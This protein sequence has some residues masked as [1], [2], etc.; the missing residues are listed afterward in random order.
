MNI[1]QWVRSPTVYKMALI[2]VS[3]V[4]AYGW[5]L[6]VTLEKRN[7]LVQSFSQEGGYLSLADY[8]WSNRSARIAKRKLGLDGD[9]CHFYGEDD[10]ADLNAIQEAAKSRVGEDVVDPDFTIRWEGDLWMR[11]KKV[12]WRVGYFPSRP[13][14]CDDPLP[15]ACDTGWCL[16]ILPAND[17]GIEMAKRM[18]AAT[19][20]RFEVRE[21]STRPTMNPD[22]ESLLSRLDLVGFGILGQSKIYLDRMLDY[23]STR[24]AGSKANTPHSSDGSSSSCPL[25]VF[26]PSFAEH[27]ASRQVPMSITLA[28]KGV[29]GMILLENPLRGRRSHSVDGERLHSMGQF[30]AFAVRA[31]SDTRSILHWVDLNLAPDRLCVGGLSIGASIAIM[32]AITIRNLN[33]TPLSLCA[34]FPAASAS[35]TW[36]HERSAMRPYVNPVLERDYIEEATAATD[37]T[38]YPK[39]ANLSSSRVELLGARH[40]AIVLGDNTNKLSEYLGC[41]IRWVRGGHVTGALLQQYEFIQAI[42]RAVC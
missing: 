28:S 8:W 33:T 22:G 15:R 4:G 36:T 41:P 32:S 1:K 34:L 13:L 20:D 26:L 11:Y 37:I 21:S 16:V 2:G 14:Q 39:P 25:V 27:Y 30:L 18:S 6:Q 31:V 38:T 5:Y 42:T 29:C 40:D 35:S 10:A 12:L 3:L 17:R 9:L 7:A 19:D 24:L 23:I